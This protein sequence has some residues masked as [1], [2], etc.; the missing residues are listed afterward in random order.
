MKYNHSLKSRRTLWRWSIVL[1]VLLWGNALSLPAQQPNMRAANWFFNKNLSLSFSWTGTQ[2]LAGTVSDIVSPMQATWGCSS[3]STPTGGLLFYSNGQTVWGNNHL[4][5]SN[6][7]GLSGDASAKRSSIIVP[8][9]PVIPGDPTEYYIFYTTAAHNLMYAVIKNNSGVWDVALKNQGLALDG[10]FAV[11]NKVGQALTA[12]QHDNGRDYWLLAHEEKGR[13]FY[14]YK[15]SPSGISSARAFTT[16][17]P[18]TDGAN[19][20]YTKFSPNGKYIGATVQGN[21]DDEGS[22]QLL[23]YKFDASTG[24]INEEIFAQRQIGFFPSDDSENTPYVPSALEFSQCGRYVYVAGR[25]RHYFGGTKYRYDVFQYPIDLSSQ[26][27]RRY[28]DPVGGKPNHNY[29]WN[30]YPG[31]L[32]LAPD[33]NIYFAFTT[34]GGSSANAFYVAR[35]GP[36]EQADE[37]SYLGSTV[38]SQ[39]PNPNYYS[40]PNVVTSYV[41][42]Y[43]DQ[44]GSQYIPPC[45]ECVVGGN[46]VLWSTVYVANVAP[47]AD[48]PSGGLIMVQYQ[49]RNCGGVME[50]R[51]VGLRTNGTGFP[52]GKYTPDRLFWYL[53]DKMLTSA[54][55]PN[56]VLPTLPSGSTTRTVVRFHTLRCWSATLCT[57]LTYWWP[58]SDEFCCYR[59][60]EV[61]LDCDNNLTRFNMRAYTNSQGKGNGLLEGLAYDRVDRDW[62]CGIK[63]LPS[64]V[65]ET[66]G[67]PTSIF[68]CRMLECERID[69][70]PMP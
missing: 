1:L 58:C 6:G 3:M 24:I 63:L 42:M 16:G 26:L 64:T 67:N 60:Y 41:N 61:G 37:V 69:P 28:R 35:F 59:E 7:T 29:H 27:P 47:P 14:I 22:N 36:K 46:K 44:G 38:Y 23:I 62:V 55:S 30:I 15:I 45:D 17:Q 68:S 39:S 33:G 70:T 12:C 5:L 49:T 2:I 52:S 54:Y 65:V 31:D 10:E 4:A 53:E 66:C 51:I 32:Q 9:P 56:F 13:H 18:R 48:Y 40:L 57:G 21:D 34:D 20:L 11:D 19:R 25:G 43:C 50:L 8:K